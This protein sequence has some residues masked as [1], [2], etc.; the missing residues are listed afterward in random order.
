MQPETAAFR[1]LERGEQSQRRQNT[2]IEL[3]FTCKTAVLRPQVIPTA[4][5]LKVW[6]PI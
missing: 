6:P 5:V 1:E 2:V 3:L 4:F